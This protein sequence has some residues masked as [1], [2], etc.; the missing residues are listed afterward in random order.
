M[1]VKELIKKLEKFDPDD[2]VVIEQEYNSTGV[3]VNVLDVIQHKYQEKTV[4][5]EGKFWH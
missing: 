3:S 1:V 5:I 2:K 4:L